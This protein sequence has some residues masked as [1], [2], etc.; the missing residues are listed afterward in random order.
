MPLPDLATLIVHYSKDKGCLPCCLNLDS[1]NPEAEGSGTDTDS[2]S[3]DDWE[4]V[5]PDYQDMKALRLGSV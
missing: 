2:D 4:A 3:D 1:F 5:D